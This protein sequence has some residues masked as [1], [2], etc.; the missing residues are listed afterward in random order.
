MILTPSSLVVLVSPMDSPSIPEVKDEY[1][2]S[3]AEM[4]CPTKG[5]C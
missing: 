2:N 4:G 3:M 1:S 5:R